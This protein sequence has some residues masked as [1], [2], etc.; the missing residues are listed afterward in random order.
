MY[1]FTWPNI[2]N[3]F[4]EKRLLVII[5]MLVTLFGI[6]AETDY[7]ISLFYIVYELF[8]WVNESLSQ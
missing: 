3:R 8:F 5:S 7:Q 4:N 1:F 6:E 2:A